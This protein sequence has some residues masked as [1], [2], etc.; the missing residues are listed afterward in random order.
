MKTLVI[1]KTATSFFLPVADLMAISLFASAEEARYYLQG[2]FMEC[3]ES[4][5]VRLV[6]TDGHSLGLAVLP[7]PAYIGADA[8]RESN[9]TNGG[10]IIK[11]DMAE[12][13]FKA[14]TVC[15][16]WAYGDTESGILQ[17]V[18]FDPTTYEN[19]PTEAFPRVGVCE[20]SDPGGDFPDWRRVMPRETD[21][22]AVA[23]FNMDYLDT[24]NKA[25]R[26]YRRSVGR[27]ARSANVTINPGSANGD[28]MDIAL[29]D[30]PHFKGVLM[31][32]RA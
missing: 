3:D 28:P 8:V 16:A 18:D 9:G 27:P 11:A 13:C 14:K 15:P 21:P 1:E 22:A 20:F 24:F 32:V 2:A 10:L 25:A 7:E 30:A 29:H 17:I 6:A 31:P 12:K 4:G 5:T 26:V 23:A 19:K